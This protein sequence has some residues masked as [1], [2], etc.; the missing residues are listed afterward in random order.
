M[1]S[2]DDIK[3]KLNIDELDKDTRSNMFNK[4]VEKGGQVVEEEKKKQ[5]ITHFN[6]DVQKTVN[7]KMKRKNDD[8]KS[9]QVYEDKNKQ[10]RG[11][12]A[13]NHKEKKTKRYLSVFFNGLFQGIFT[14]SNKFTPKFSTGMQDEFGTIMSSLNYAAGLVLN[15]EAEKKWES[16]EMINRTGASNY[17][18]L[19]R[20][21]NLYKINSITRIQNSFKRFNNIICPEIVDDLN[22]FYKEI[23][24]LHPYW[25]TIKEVM[26]KAMLVYQ[27]FTKREPLIPKPKLNKFVDTLMGYYFPNIH[28][29]LN[30]N[31]GNKI[32]YEYGLMYEKAGI[33]S[34]EEFGVFAR[35]MIDEKKFYLAQI[36]KEKEERKKIFEDSVE[37]KEM[38]KIPKY[39]QKG[40]QIIDG[41]IEKIPSKVNSD[42]KAK[43]LQKNE[44]MLQFYYLFKEF[45]EEYSFILTTSQIRLTARSEGGKRI[46][47]KQELEELNIKFN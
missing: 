31:R 4:F 35:Q 38:D 47:V 8:L 6:K 22:L 43:N 30:Y 26:W 28:I 46:D 5:R 33:T 2:F 45:D 25:E 29:I 1:A 23:L 11:T 42:N 12:G 27:E 44:K 13:D 3:K 41:V 9:K 20:I 17:E 10:K 40:L 39:I 14:L 19:M 37:K 21:Y 16:Y 7:E 34:E 36:E 18:I 15:L 32:P 24:I